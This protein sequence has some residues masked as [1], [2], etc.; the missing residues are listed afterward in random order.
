[1]VRSG[2]K[3]LQGIPPYTKNSAAVSLPTF[4]IQTFTCVV[5]V[6]TI[7]SFVFDCPLCIVIIEK[8]AFEFRSKIN[9]R[10]LRVKKSYLRLP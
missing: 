1:M 3:N 10:F 8:E 4:L 9:K 6:I 7:T 2:K 5:Y